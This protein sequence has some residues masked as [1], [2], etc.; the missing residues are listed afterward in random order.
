M[1]CDLQWS[2]HSAVLAKL[3]GVQYIYS[4]LLYF[5]ETKNFK[6]RNLT[7]NFEKKAKTCLKNDIDGKPSKAESLC[8]KIQYVAAQ[9]YV[10]Y[11]LFLH[12]H[13]Y[14]KILRQT[15]QLFCAVLWFENPFNGGLSKSVEVYIL[16]KRFHYREL[17]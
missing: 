10:A 11:G 14:S 17:F 15:K 13:N 4:N 16:I 5:E 3:K 2:T 7:Y 12:C 8:P 6:L 1:L 9:I